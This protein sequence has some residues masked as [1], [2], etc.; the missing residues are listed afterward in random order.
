MFSHLCANHSWIQFALGYFPY[1][2]NLFIHWSKLS[3]P[4]PKS[5]TLL[6]FNTYIMG[7]RKIYSRKTLSAC[8]GSNYQQLE[9]AALCCLKTM[10]WPKLYAFVYTPSCHFLY[11]KHDLWEADLYKPWV[12]EW[13]P[14][15]WGCVDEHFRCFVQLW[16]D[17]PQSTSITFVNHL[18]LV[19]MTP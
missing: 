8:K 16:T 13:A 3:F 19:A 6:I 17:C 1:C 14:F 9:N 11:D 12:S 15:E 4:F 18:G 5:L 7:G 10:A 2:N